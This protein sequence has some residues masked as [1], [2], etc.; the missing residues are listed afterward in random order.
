MFFKIPLTNFFI[1]KHLKTIKYPRVNLMEDSV[2]T[3]HSWNARNKR[4]TNLKLADLK[5]RNVRKLAN[6]ML[7]GPARGIPWCYQ[8]FLCNKWEWNEVQHNSYGIVAGDKLHSIYIIIVKVN[9]GSCHNQLYLPISKYTNRKNEFYL[10]MCSILLSSD[11]Y[12][13]LIHWYNP[14][15]SVL[16]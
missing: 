10:K 2:L 6:E 5:Q 15:K 1:P 3:Y 9:P 8:N 7:L 11:K 13:T 12:F 4:G 16:V 14:E